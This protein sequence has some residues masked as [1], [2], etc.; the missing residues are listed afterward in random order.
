MNARKAVEKLVPGDVVLEPG[1]GEPDRLRIV[2]EVS[3][4]THAVDLTFRDGMT[5]PFR[6]GFEVETA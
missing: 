3:I 2:A 1:F 4:K 6:V 5:S